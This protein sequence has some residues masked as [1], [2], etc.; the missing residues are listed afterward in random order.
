MWFFN[1]PFGEKHFFDMSILYLIYLI[2]Q[3]S[4]I[5]GVIRKIIFI[6]YYSRKIFLE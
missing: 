6:I 2:D 5:D 3:I 1:T 4:G